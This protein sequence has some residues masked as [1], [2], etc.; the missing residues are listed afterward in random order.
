MITRIYIDNYKCLS[1][2]ELK[3]GKLGLLLG[4][5]GSGKSS[6]FEAIWAIAAL[7][8]R[9]DKTHSLFGGKT[10]CAWDTR[11]DQVFELDL[12]S[13]QHEIKYTLQV[14]FDENSYLS[15]I[16]RETL[17]VD[18]NLIM[19][20]ED[21]KVSII[22][23]ETHEIRE[24]FLD[25]SFSGI[26]V[27]ASQL[28]NENIVVFRDY[29]SR[30][31]FLRLMPQ[32]I[33]SV[34]KNENEMLFPNGSNF[35]S[36]YQFQLLNQVQSFGSRITTTLQHVIPGLSGIRFIKSGKT[37]RWLQLDFIDSVRKIPIPF[38]LEDLSEGQRALI[39][40][41]TLLCCSSEK[42][43]T[44][45]LDEPDNYIG[46]SELQPWLQSLV[47]ACGNN[48]SQALII[49]HHPELYNYLGRD[50]GI[51]F[52]RSPIGPTRIVPP[53]DLSKWNLPLSELAARGWLP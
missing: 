52:D 30:F 7:V 3:P 12:T 9:D 11:K 18:D 23:P 6:V 53:P 40:L 31:I 24:Y 10:I 48:V 42:P 34:S 38:D 1:N 13:N 26:S 49:S 4:T 33:T 21:G 27:L 2:F 20:C 41:Y 29:I 19:S 8:T 44:L 37:E 51:W 28:R 45:F 16:N 15:E 46:L 5:N 25:K 39:V 17:S 14:Q 50:Y 43:L 22:S 36:W 47:D 32:M 35:T